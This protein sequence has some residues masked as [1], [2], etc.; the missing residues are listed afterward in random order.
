MKPGHIVS[1]MVQAPFCHVVAVIVGICLSE[2]AVRTCG[3]Y[4]VRSIQCVQ[5]AD[6]YCSS[7]MVASP[8]STSQS[9]FNTFDP[10]LPLS[11]TSKLDAAYSPNVVADDLPYDYFSMPTGGPD[12]PTIDSGLIFRGLADAPISPSLSSPACYSNTGFGLPP[13]W[14]GEGDSDSC[15]YDMFGASGDQEGPLG[16]KPAMGISGYHTAIGEPTSSRPLKRSGSEAPPGLVSIPPVPYMKSP[17]NG[18]QISPMTFGPGGIAEPTSKGHKVQLRTASRKPKRRLK[19]P[20]SPPHTPSEESATHEDDLLTPEELRARRNHNNVEKQYRNRLNAQFE[21]LLAALPADQRT[22]SGGVGLGGLN[23]VGGEGPN[24]EKRMS[25]GEV[26]DLATRRI[27]ALER[28]KARLQQERHELQ[29]NVEA[30]TNAMPQPR[31]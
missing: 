23:Q 18:Y 21:R 13:A 12:Y 22:G 30:L 19:H 4:H 17:P 7:Q 10:S 20:F 5:T 2:P 28:E 11:A 1:T 3:F 14:T 31:P 8:T 24:G 6:S 25:K 15:D 16:N 29:K 9:F 27:N 26:L